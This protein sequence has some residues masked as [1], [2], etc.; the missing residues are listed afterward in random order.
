M[1]KGDIRRNSAGYYDPTAW[2]AIA[3]IE[4]ETE[5]FHRL[6]DVIHGVCELSG[7]R[8]KERIVVEDKKTGRVWR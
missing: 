7:F 2:K 8:L 5:R 1:S 4:A 6:L 3:N